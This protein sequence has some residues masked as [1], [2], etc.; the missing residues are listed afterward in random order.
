MPQT[1][2]TVK[3]FKPEIDGTQWL[4]VKLSHQLGDG[5]L[6]TRVEMENG[7]L[8]ADDAATEDAEPEPPLDETTPE[9]TEDSTTEPPAPQEPD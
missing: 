7:A 2:V 5:G 3:G 4:V 9:D 8:P 6:L 1:P